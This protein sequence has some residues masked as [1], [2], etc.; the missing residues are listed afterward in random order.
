MSYSPFRCIDK[1]LFARVAAEARENRRLRF[2]HNFHR[3]QDPVQ[4]FL[5]VLQPGTNVHPHRHRRNGFGT[6]F[7]CF[8]LLQGAIGLLL[9]NA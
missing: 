8:L 5:N 2:N 9:F 7:E 4:R 6:G 3:E 1:Q